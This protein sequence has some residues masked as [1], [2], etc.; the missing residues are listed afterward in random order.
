MRDATWMRVARAASTTATSAA[1]P[2]V[3]GLGW[4][5]G[6]LAVA[7]VPHAPHLPAWVSL[8]LLA[9]GGWRW[10][11]SLRGW[12]LAPRW[13]RIVIVVVATVAILGTY[14]TL[15]GIEAGTALLVLMAAAKLLETRSSRDL[16]VL[17]F[18]AWFLLFAAL[19]RDQRLVQLPWLFGS[20]FL[21]TVALMR[22]HAD[23]TAAP[24]THLARRSLTLLAQAVPVGIMLFLLFPRLPGPFWGIDARSQAR[25]GL[26]DEMTPGDVSDLSASGEVAFRVRFRGEIP[27][28]AQRYWRGPVLHEFDGR[29]WRRPR[30]QAFPQQET[31]FVGT[32]VD[33]QVTLEPHD[34]RWV[35]ALDLPS[36]W[37]ER[38]AF[39]TYDFTLLSARTVG[40]VTAFDLSSHPRFVAGVELPESLR[41]KDLALPDDGTNARSLQLGRELA[42]RHRGDPLLIVGE[43]L[44]RFR[45]E[46]FEYTMRPPLLADNAVDEFLFET[47]RGFCEHYAS[48]FTVV[49]RA[50][51][52]PARVVTGYQG[53]EF[54]PFGGY[55]IVRQS[56]AHAWSEVWVDGRGWLRVDPTA[57]V[58]PERIESGLIDAVGADEPVPGRLREASPFVMRLELGWDAVNDFWNQR[59]V[60]FDADAQFELLERLGVDDPDWRALGLGLAASLAAFFAGLSAYLAWRYR[61]PPRDWP[62]RLHDVV[63]R[64]LRRRGLV[65]GPAEGPI[66]FLQR[67]ERTHPDLAQAL[68]EIR[69]LYTAQRYGPSPRLPELQR[70]KHLVNALRP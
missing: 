6:A 2:P 46:P 53:G 3:H 30:A 44:R 24:A 22:V 10:A 38:E 4:V 36:Q 17:V 27:S 43:L 5:L 59:V 40:R 56:D 1:R 49:M 29:S 61:P 26:D 57:A 15:N 58:A 65:Q 51:G 23:A 63:A 47:R 37:P 39:Q 7:V 64:R 66:A 33:Y 34:R 8:L 25:T 45:T 50:A 14:R 12:P 9:V 52:V 42:A 20:A 21:S 48:A 31:R 18:I 35:F 62:A 28:A 32:A 67:A 11:A 60:R 70:L 68:A 16:T 54:N 19:L 69:V 41:R 55:L 13:L